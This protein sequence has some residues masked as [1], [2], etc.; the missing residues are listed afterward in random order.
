MSSKKIEICKHT[1]WDR[2][3]QSMYA[4]DVDRLGMEMLLTVYNESSLEAVDVPSWPPYM[5]DTEKILNPLVPC[6]KTI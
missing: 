5:T 6:R 3:M 1:G 4:S 2:W